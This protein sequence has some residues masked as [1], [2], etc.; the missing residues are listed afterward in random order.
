MKTG[1]IYCSTNIINNKKY[2]GQTIRDFN[3]RKSLHIKSA[4]QHNSN[5]KFHQALRKHGE[6]SFIWEILEDNVLIENL[7]EREIYWVNHY[8]TLDKG[9]NMTAGGDTSL[10]YHHTPEMKKYLSDNAKG[11][12]NKDH[13]IARY[14][15][16]EGLKKYEIYI[17]K[18]KE[19][20]GKSRLSLMI[21]KHGEIEGT[22]M[23]N[24]MVENIR[25]K[26]RGKKLSEEHKKK[27]G[28]GGRGKIMSEEFKQKQRNRKVSEETKQKI[29]KAQKGKYVSPETREKIG[30][31]W[32]G[33]TLSEEH[34]Q[35]IKEGM[36][37][38]PRKDFSHSLQSKE[39]ISISLKKMYKEKG[40]S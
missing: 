13:Y 27:I 33:K 34:K 31:I 21:E 23:Y 37:K 14:G 17:N 35:H 6:N 11:K 7:N 12:S 25:N 22:R 1:I 30:K 20:K 36:R 24:S 40:E 26:H 5:L 10:G 16:E 38:N 9:Y 4:F 18:L 32:K 39:K 2:I 3:Y 28:D 19:R 15:E 29:S 8:N